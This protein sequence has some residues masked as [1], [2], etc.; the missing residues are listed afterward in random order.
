MTARRL[1]SKV[2]RRAMGLPYY[3]QVFQ[4]LK[5]ADRHRLNSDQRQVIILNDRVIKRQN[6][7]LARIELEKT[8]RAARIGERCGW[9]HVPR[10]V[11]TDE[12]AGEIHFEKLR[13]VVP[14][15]FAV[16]RD[17]MS[18]DILARLG[19]SVAAIHNELELPLEMSIESEP[20]WGGSKAYPKVYIHGDMKNDNI[21]VGLDTRRLWIIDW[22]DDTSRTVG[23]CYFDL[24]KFVEMILQTRYLG[25]QS[26]RDVDEK[27]DLLLG[28]YFADAQHP[29]DLRG[30][31]LYLSTVF[32]PQ[33]PL[34][35]K[36]SSPSSWRQLLRHWYLG[37][38]NSRLSRFVRRFDE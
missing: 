36:S 17:R 20:P 21:L 35:M 1:I 14:F 4:N 25:L 16:R 32:V 30:F 26:V 24:A 18:D 7:L 12:N 34:L 15:W 8:R 9:F 6:P 37:T 2:A 5:E 22:W 11:D 3:A 23:P 19:H 29:C 28:T 27:I 33:F 31:Q 10:I 13:D 38:S